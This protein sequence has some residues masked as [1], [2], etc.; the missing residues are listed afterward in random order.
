MKIKSQ[1]IDGRTEYHTIQEIV[2]NSYKEGERHGIILGALGTIA[3]IA[4]M[5]LF[6]WAIGFIRV[7]AQ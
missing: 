2:W 5:H 3:A 4:V 7:V 1:S 6:A